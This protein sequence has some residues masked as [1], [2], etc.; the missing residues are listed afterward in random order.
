MFWNISYQ[1]NPT[2]FNLKK[3]IQRLE[4]ELEKEKNKKRDNIKKYYILK[5]DKRN[6]KRK[7]ENVIGG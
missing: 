3:E 1:L 5:T 2:L 6:I 4:Q 7:L